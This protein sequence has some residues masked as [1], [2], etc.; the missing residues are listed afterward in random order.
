MKPQFVDLF[1]EPCPVIGMVHVQALPGTPFNRFSLSEIRRMAVE[2]ARLYAGEGVEAIMLENMH[3]VPYL[4]REVGHEVSTVMAVI[5]AAVRVAVDLPCG[6]QILAG[7]N[8]AALAAAQA[9][10][11]DFI[12][13]E[14]FVFGHV[15]DEGWMSADA[16]KLLRYRRKIGAD[17]IC[18]L[19]DIKKKHAAHATTADVD[20]LETAKAADFFRSDGLIVTG[21]A[22]GAQTSR[23]DLENLHGQTSLPVLVGSGITVEN[24]AHYFPL[25]D[26]MIIGSYFKRNGD[27]REPPEAARVRLLMQRMESLRQGN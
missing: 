23:A 15:A 25:C 3:D 21:S 6:L 8:L 14:G 5:A 18:V 12:R 20:L 16:G 4:N 13:A 19:T 7:A 26:G 11:L 27:W 22:T 9:A 17:K 24:I 1:T 2:E 10:G